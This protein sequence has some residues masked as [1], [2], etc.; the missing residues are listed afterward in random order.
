MNQLLK[1][2]KFLF[3][4]VNVLLCS[5][6]Y[7]E[8]SIPKEKLIEKVKYFR[9]KIEQNGPTYIK[10]GQIL[11]VRYDFF[12]E[13]ACHELQKLLDDGEKL[14][15]S[16]IQ[17]TLKIHLNDQ[18]YRQIN[19]IEPEPIGV[20]SLGQVHRAV[21]N[22]GEVVAIK[23]QKPNIKARLKKDLKFLARASH[24]TKFIPVINKLRLYV[25]IEEFC[26]FTLR[27]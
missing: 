2:L 6:K 12:P 18:A 5:K 13:F 26:T 7:R 10:F 14:P 1:N 4:L 9:E 19:Y 21:L 15:F 11:S 3:L 20:A 22:T 24:I 8:G 17:E 27:N 23:V 25:F 16:Y